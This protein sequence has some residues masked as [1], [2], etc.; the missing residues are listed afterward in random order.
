MDTVYTTPRAALVNWLFIATA[1]L[2][3]LPTLAND[4]SIQFE[5]GAH[6]NYLDADDYYKINTTSVSNKSANLQYGLDIG[7]L[8]HFDP[9]PPKTQLGIAWSQTSG[10]E[11][12]AASFCN[13]QP[14]TK[15]TSLEF[16]SLEV[17]AHHQWYESEKMQA[18][19]F[20]GISHV[21]VK[22]EIK[23]DTWSDSAFGA[24]IGTKVYFLPGQKIQPFIGVKLMLFGLE[25]A[26]ESV[27]LAN[28]SV[29]LG[30][31]F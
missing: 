9:L 4:T 3:S 30:A 13:S 26:D 1:A 12:D 28:L 14:C 8:L 11:A 23:Q 5:V 15:T 19:I 7:I 6:A 2:T 17:N 25:A 27:N 10:Y 16:Q 24:Q 20:A 29:L 21:W 31:R 18:S 22:G